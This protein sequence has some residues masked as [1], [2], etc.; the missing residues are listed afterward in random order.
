MSPEIL[1]ALQ[2]ARTLYLTTYRRDGRAGTVPIWFFQHQER[3]YFCTLRDSLKVRR[4][5]HTPQVT[6]HIGRR[7]GT[8]LTCI[9]RVL[10]D[11]PQLQQLLVRTY[12]KRYWFRWLLLGQRLRRIV[13]T[14]RAKKLFEFAQALRDPLDPGFVAIFEVVRIGTAAL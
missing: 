8:R 10:E 7:T 4:L 3:L 11:A 9:A 2:H 5:Q 6:V 13:E 1:H 12:R 14:P